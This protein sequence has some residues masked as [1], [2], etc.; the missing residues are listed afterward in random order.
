MLHKPYKKYVVLRI[1]AFLI[2]SAKKKTLKVKLLKPFDFQPVKTR[3]P[4]NSTVNIR[5]PPVL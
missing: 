4:I 5:Y 3:F 2:Y 1:F